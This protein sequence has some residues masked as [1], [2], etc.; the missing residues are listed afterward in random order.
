ML[1]NSTLINGA[2]AKE[3]DKLFAEYNDLAIKI[4]DLTT[5]RD[6]IVKRIKE[7]CSESGVYETL[8]YVLTMAEVAGRVSVD[9]KVLKEKYPN[10]FEECSKVSNGYLQ[11]SSIKQKKNKD[12]RV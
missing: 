8:D 5:T 1:E 7:L 2:Q 10:I 6:S 11:I 3:L 12:T 4:K 9:S